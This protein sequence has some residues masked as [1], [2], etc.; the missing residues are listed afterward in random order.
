MWLSLSSLRSEWHVWQ[1][2]L[3]NCLQD[4][5]ILI[6]LHHFNL[7][8]KKDHFI[9]A[10]LWSP[11]FWL[12]SWCV[13]ASYSPFVSEHHRSFEPILV[14][15]LLRKICGLFSFSKYPLSSPLISFPFKWFQLPCHPSQTSITSTHDPLMYLLPGETDTKRTKGPLFFYEPTTWNQH[16]DHLQALV[17]PPASSATPSSSSPTLSCSTCF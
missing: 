6:S 17:W 8:T 2:F 15:S 14:G 7:S 10:L 5:M 16:F 4:G 3:V 1:P 9:S 12:Y 11:P 13:C